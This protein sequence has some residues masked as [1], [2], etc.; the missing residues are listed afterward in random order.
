MT[1][2]HIYTIKYLHR[3]ALLRYYTSGLREKPGYVTS[4]G[5]Y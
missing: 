4:F 5:T 2:T 3:K 1:Q